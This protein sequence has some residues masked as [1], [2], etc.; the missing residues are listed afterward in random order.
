[1]S[2][3]QSAW[4][5]VVESWNGARLSATDAAYPIT[6]QAAQGELLFEYIDVLPDGLVEIPSE[7]EW[8][9]VG[10][11]ETG[12]HHVLRSTRVRH[13]RDTRNATTTYLLINEPDELTHLRSFDTHR[14]L[15]FH[16]GVVRVDHQREGEME[17]WRRAAD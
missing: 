5:A 17:E 7:N 1:M 13:F 16:P 3:A 12:H 2:A 4:D 14:S 6:G 15:A 8:V 10:H 11:S 9:I